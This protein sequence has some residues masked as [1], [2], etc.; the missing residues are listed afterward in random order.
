MFVLT[1]E[2]ALDRSLNAS[3]DLILIIAYQEP[4]EQ[5]FSCLSNEGFTCEVSRQKHTEEYKDYSP[6][7]RCLL[8]HREAWKRVIREDKPVLIVEADFVPVK[9]F[10]QLP[11]PFDLD[12]ADTGIAW[13]YT[14]APQIYSVSLQGFATGFSTSAVAYIITPNAARILLQLEERIRQ[15]PGP[16]IYS[17][18][19]SS[20]EGILRE[21]KL[22]SYLPF[23]NYGE[24][25]GLPNLEHYRHH[26]SKV[27]RADVLY[28]ELAFLPLYTRGKR[29]ETLAFFRERI[30]ARLKGIA[31]LF[32]GKYLRPAMI[33][34]AR[35]P[36]RLLRFAI[37]RQLTVRL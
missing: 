10:G 18:W 30:R 4:T 16:K 31:R 23:R 26:L 13:L 24:H 29:N 19:D 1:R 27:H 20:I 28:G 6:S 17:T 2:R 14:C 33:R 3:I 34:R 9:G 15:N 32:A 11:L 5:L 25:G 8:N 7:Y 12:R 37:Q 36:D 22:K 21:N 35:N